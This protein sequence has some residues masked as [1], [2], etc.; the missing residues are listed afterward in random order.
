MITS[1]LLSTWE[2]CEINVKWKL[3]IF[4]L[5]HP[6]MSSQT[7]H[8]LQP[9][10]PSLGPELLGGFEN[11]VWIV[12]MT[13]TVQ[14][15][16]LGAFWLDSEYFKDWF[17]SSLLIVQS[18]SYIKISCLHTNSKLQSLIGVRRFITDETMICHED[19]SHTWHGG[20]RVVYACMCVHV[21]SCPVL[22]HPTP[23]RRW[24]YII[25]CPSMK[26]GICSFHDAF[27]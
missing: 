16:L 21:S 20:P 7:R 26:K 24:T 15:W 12:P 10:G 1:Q 6:N 27:L 17:F 22:S 18:V 8:S 25:H 4:D 19:V 23:V 5:F 13:K 2:T 3:Q 14:Q 11:W 9:G